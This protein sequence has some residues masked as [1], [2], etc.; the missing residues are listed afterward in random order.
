[1]ALMISYG[2]AHQYYKLQTKCHSKNNEI[3]TKNQID[4]Q[5]YVNKWPR[6]VALL[7]W[8]LLMLQFQ[9]SCLQAQ[10]TVLVDFLQEQHSFWLK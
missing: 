7:K 6:A 5:R 3:L 8:Y 9:R 10:G 1:M 2:D 4:L